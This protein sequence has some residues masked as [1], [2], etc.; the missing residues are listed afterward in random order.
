MSKAVKTIVM[1]DYDS[2]LGE[3]EDAVMISLRGLKGTATTKLRNDL[4]KKNIKVTVV[5]NAL[6]R[7]AFE[8]RS[9]G[10]LM[11]GA[12]GQNALAYGAGS[13]VEVAREIVD[14]IKT[15]K[16]I[17]LKAAILDGEVFSGSEGV[18]RLSKFPTRTEAIAKDVTL[19]ISPGRKLLGA[20]KGPGSRVAGVIAAIKE[21]LEKGEAIAPK[22]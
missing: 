15:F 11:Q 2:R 21:K 12:Q 8:G 17:E 10:K 5:R 20:V 22:A 9:I 14:A 7:K 18:E 1:R 19:I 16:D 13:V 4:A 3:Y 6:A